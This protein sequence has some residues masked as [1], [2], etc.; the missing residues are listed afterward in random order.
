MAKPREPSPPRVM[1]SLC[2]SC[3]ACVAVCPHGAI[4]LRGEELVIDPA[5]CKGEDRCRI[6]CPA[7]ALLR[8]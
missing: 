6:L 4:R 3:D 8:P 7:G 1:Q 2:R 5:L